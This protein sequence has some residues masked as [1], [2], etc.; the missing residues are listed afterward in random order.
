MKVTR[1]IAVLL[2]V[3]LLSAV[4]V[5]PATAASAWPD[6]GLKVNLSVQRV[7]GSD[8]Y[9]TAV[10]IAK[11]TYPGWTDVA[12]VVV[13]SGE[14]RALADPLAAGSLCWA[15]DAPLLLVTG[16]GVPAPVK[17]ALEEIRSINDTVTVTVVGG[18]VAVSPAAV[19]ELEAIVG[20]GNVTQPWIT[21]DRY[22]TAAG[23]AQLTSEV[24]SDTARTIPAR[25]FVANGTDAAGFV[26]ALAASAVSAATGIPVLL[27]EKDRVPAATKGVIDASPPGSVVVVGGTAVV[28]GAAYTAAG[29]TTRWWGA[30]RYGTA[31]VIAT[32]AR[33]RSWLTGS[34]VGMA[35]AV[36]DA[37]AGATNIGRSG[38]PLLYVYPHTV[39][40]ATAGYVHRNGGLVNSARLFGGT[41]VLTEGL[42]AEIKGAP[43][44]PRVVAPTPTSWV[45]KKARVVVA[46]G[47]NTTEVKVYTGTTLV[48]SKVCP[49]YA[50]V[51]LGVIPTPADGSTYRIV[52]RNP[53]GGE[54]SASA[55]YRRHSYP[56][57]TSIVVDKSDFRLYFFRNDVFV[58]SYPIAHGKPR[59]PTPV[60]IWRIDSKYY[61]DPAGVYGP[62]KMRMYRKIGSSYV[63]T[64]YAIHGTNQPWVIGTQASAGCIRMYNRDVLELF[65]QVPLGTIVQTRL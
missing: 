15:Y 52:S 63:R 10:A 51:D 12:H 18:P 25:A 32:G 58:K 57:P 43:T 62:R 41:A 8:R 7:A 11:Q 23:I 48:A 5:L 24:A 36:P 38:G 29:G 6:G 56:A 14:K 37:L 27:V 31:A 39:G 64:G 34:T 61:T 2:G 46:T 20:A 4:P 16:S 49:S 21:G 50:T 28:S 55:G 22:T 60:A 35:S 59:T 9:G 26:D 65:P 1:S 19:A 40:P 54:S 3:A 17:V 33:N 45:G 47:V 44:A 53:D 13:A 42:V 30:D